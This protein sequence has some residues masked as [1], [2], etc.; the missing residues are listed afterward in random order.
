MKPFFV[1][2]ALLT[3]TVGLF[4]SASA[5]AAQAISPTEVLEGQ[6]QVIWVDDFTRTDRMLPP[7]VLLTS[8]HGQQARVLPSHDAG[9]TLADLLSLEGETVKIKGEWSHAPAQAD[10]QGVLLA[11]SAQPVQGEMVPES[12]ESH[13][14]GNQPWLNILCKFADIPDEPHNLAYFQ[15]MFASDY[16]G[17]DYYW[18]ELSYDQ[19]N[20]EGS[21]AYGWFTLPHPRSSY[22]PINL[23]NL[24]Q[25]CAAAAD[26]FVYFPDFAGVNYM[27]NANLGDYAYGGKMGVFVDG[28]HM[29]LPST[30]LSHAV[31]QNIAG[32]AHEM[33]H[34][35]G[36]PHSSGDY[37]KIYD[38]PWDV[39]SIPGGAGN[40][41]H[42]VYQYPGQHTIA[43]YKSLLGWI[44]PE[45]VV[46][47]PPGSQVTVRL[48]RL[49]LPQT[50]DPLLIKI[51]TTGLQRD[52]YTV[53]ARRRDGFDRQLPGS[54]VIIHKVNTAIFHSP[55][56]LV[57]VDR[58]GNT[59]DEGVMWKEGET[60]TDEANG[61]S[62]HINERT[63]TGFVVTVTAP[64]W[65]D[66]DCSNQ[67]QLHW[68]ECN[69]LVR[70][71]THTSGVNWSPN[72]YPFDP[73]PCN[74]EG[75]TCTDDHVTGL[76]LSAF[77]L[78]GS[79]P[80]DIADLAYLEALDLSRNELWDLI[81]GEIGNLTRL[82]SL[83]L[84]RNRFSGG[85][86]YALANLSEV[87]EMR[88]DSN[89]LSGNIP[90]TYAGMPGL[91]FLD[92]SNNILYGKVPPEFGNVP[93]Y[94]TLY[95]H[96]NM[97]HSSDPG[98][99]ALLDRSD[100][101]WESTQNVAPENLAVSAASWDK[102][103]LTWTPILF[104]DGEGY[105]EVGCND[106]SF[107]FGTLCAQT[108]DKTADGI[109]IEGL[110]PG[111][112]HYLAVRTFTPAHD[113]QKNDLWSLEA[114]PIGVT[115]PEKP[116]PDPGEPDP[117]DPD[118]GDPDPAPGEP[119]PGDPDPGDPDP[120]PG[121]PDPDQ[122]ETNRVLFLPFLRKGK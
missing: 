61:V 109:V 43:Y 122:G 15:G 48:E 21:R 4:R 80:S 81:P 108:E 116:D 83:N 17:L 75:V 84:S 102:V 110:E 39:M 71:Y 58:N 56:N 37:G 41:Y 120:A 77:G 73:N 30:W 60:F 59:S 10:L 11:Q 9:L 119:D 88:L 23:F 112:T 76:N 74:W 55:A 52:F 78:D 91:A 54:A 16:P 51:Y 113:D 87:T 103:I 34:A 28:R 25:D 70:I 42:P 29:L 63:A 114:G 2:T 67:D 26:P 46:I 66:F 96:Y 89:H 44:P 45:K 117:G 50:G 118:P 49:A 32:V 53:E 3:I 68:D 64:A 40:I 82:K 57:D 97:M 6:L 111:R 93:D 36:L 14:L 99:R 33:G 31:Y 62:V 90:F 22:F 115:V 98:V 47:A 100:T 121:E 72:W 106:E 105:Y 69:A 95:L 12:V 18:R 5:I 35:F 107:R 38:S 85:I 13:I 94:F 20:L 19:I 92:V 1:L 8:E 104:S 79:L 24:A 101:G 86:P 7:V 27:F 65:Q